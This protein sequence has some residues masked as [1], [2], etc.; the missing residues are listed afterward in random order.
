MNPQTTE[1]V[2]R[3]EWSARILTLRAGYT[4]ADLSQLNSAGLRFVYQQACKGI[5][6]TITAAQVFEAKVHEL[7]RTAPI[8]REAAVAHL[9]VISQPTR[10]P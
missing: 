6:P 5:A 4:L 1:A 9:L 2:A 10:L 7:C 8:A 3:E